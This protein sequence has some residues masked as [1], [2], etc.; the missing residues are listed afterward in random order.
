MRATTVLRFA[1]DLSMNSTL[2]TDDAELQACYDAYEAGWEGILTDKASG[3]S[4][5]AVHDALTQT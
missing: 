3:I 5:C 4:T 1:I 2:G